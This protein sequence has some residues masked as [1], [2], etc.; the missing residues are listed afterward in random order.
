MRKLI[1]GHFASNNSG[2]QWSASTGT[3][4]APYFRLLSP[5]RQAERFDKEGEFIRRYLPMLSDVS[6]KALMKPGD[7]ELIKAGYPAPMIDLKV[8]REACLAAFKAVQ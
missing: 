5:L 1:D 2:W 7:P 4:A 8:A 6:A 3:D